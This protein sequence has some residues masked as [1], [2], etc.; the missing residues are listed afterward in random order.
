MVRPAL[1]G[2]L[3]LVTLAAGGAGGYWLGSHPSKKAFTAADR[4]APDPG[5]SASSR[6]ESASRKPPPAPL[7]PTEIETLLENPLR[8]LDAALAVQ[9]PDERRHR[10]LQL[11]DA[12]ARRA[13][14]DAW[15][16]AMSI[17]DPQAQRALLGVVIPLWAAQQPER[18][19]A[20][21]AE[22][23]PGW[24]RQQLLQQVAAEIARRDPLLALT[25]TASIDDVAERNPYRSRDSFRS[26]IVLEWASYDPAGAA[27]WI[28]RQNPGVRAQLT[29][30]IADAYVGQQPQQALDWALTNSRS[31]GKELWA[32]MLRHMALYD[33][34]EALR[35]ALATENTMQRNAALSGV[36]PAIA[37]IDP[38]LATSLLEKVPAGTMR[39]Q[40]IA[41]VAQRMAQTSIANAV[42]WLTSLGGAGDQQAWMNISGTVAYRNPDAAAEFV[43]RVPKHARTQWIANV[44]GAYAQSDP[45][46]AIQWAR[47][48]QDEP[49]YPR[50]VQQLS[51]SISYNDPEFTLQMIERLVD[52]KQR[53]RVIASILPMIAQ[54][55]PEIA[56][57]MLDDISN[58][59]LRAQ[60][61]ANVAVGLAQSDPAAARKL[62]M[63]L[64]AGQTRDQA[65]A[66]LIG[67]M[68]Q[69]SAE[70]TLTL[71]RD[72]QSPGVRQHVV[73]NAA[74]NLG[75]TNPEAMRT[76]LRRYP[77]DPQQQQQLDMMLQHQDSEGW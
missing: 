55:A 30:Q 44:A 3:M 26:I 13:P 39:Q 7:S 75:R 31:S 23:P 68:Q 69:A 27:Q 25:L 11:G 65:L 24:E 56:V 57:R 71:I 21:V 54:Q 47:K 66:N 38:A 43:D 33:P 42:D 22:L 52:G 32:Y 34:Q 51:M 16:E 59:H 20:S 70:E 40:V 67:N 9:E 5:E 62:V 77:L 18:A 1:I 2:A 41:E 8:S 35:I 15:N 37:A 61:T 48:F 36:L 73:L 49:G 28:E 14:E 58:E 72:I 64:P 76:L 45:D 4:R 53:Q 50:I 10:L 17:T 60:S 63:S 29:Y 74:F 12:W 46:K 6:D 19:F